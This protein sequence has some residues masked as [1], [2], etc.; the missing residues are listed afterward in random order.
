MRAG[1][2]S[3]LFCLPCWRSRVGVTHT[4]RDVLIAFPASNV[5]HTR[6]ASWADDARRRRGAF[7]GDVGEE[8]QHQVSRAQ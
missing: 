3:S 1:G 6:R 8:A 4:R 2:S 5:T 7:R